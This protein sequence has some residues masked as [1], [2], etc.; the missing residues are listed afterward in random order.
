MFFKYDPLNE[1]Y[2]SV[3][4]GVAENTSV[5]FFVRTDAERAE[6]LLYGD[7]GLISLL[8][9]KCDDGFCT[10]TS[11]DRGLYFYKF[12][13]TDGKESVI[14]GA[15]EN[16]Y[17]LCD[18]AFFQLTVCP[19]DYVT[20]DSFKGGVIYQIFPDRFYRQ[21]DFTVPD[22]K[23]ARYDWGGTPTFR[24]HDGIVYNNEFF[25][26]NFRGIK[27]KLDYISSLGITAL[28]LNPISKSYSSHRYDTG[29]YLIPDPVL[30]SYEDFHDLALEARK[31]GIRLIYDGVF[32]HTGADSRY[33]NRYGNYSDGGA[34][35]DRFSP[36]YEWYTFR[37]YPDDYE[38]WWNFPN[39]PSVK[40][41]CESYQ[42][43]ICGKNG[44]LEYWLKAGFGGVRLDVADELT[45]DFIKKIRARVKSES[46]DNPL[47]GEVWED[48][49]NKIAY[50]V[51]RR[52]FTDGE[53]DSVM[54]Y[55]LR[56]AICDY[57][58]GGDCSFLVS[59]IRSQINNYPKAALDCLMNIISTHDS[60]RAITLFGRKDVIVDKDK[61]AGERLTADEYNRG[62]ARL[63]CAS[64]VQFFLY[65]VPSIYYGDE[66]GLS[67]NLDPYN[68]RCYDWDNPD[69][70]LLAHYRKISDIRKN[71]R[72]ALKDGK[73]EVLFA[74]KGVLI[75]SRGAADEK[76]IVAVNV[77]FKS[78]I[79][80]LSRRSVDLYS[81]KAGLK[82]DLIPQSF[83]ILKATA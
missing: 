35:R 72:A 3:T 50:G 79:V 30:G 56:D 42:S 76:L 15:D 14:Y 29:D 44:V 49:T 74:E 25:G 64:V 82:F 68:R 12:K 23:I 47:I 8:L 31:R 40:K 7:N 52:Y 10:R 62:K 20:P 59:V 61:M 37:N 67:G 4:G 71:N 54:N 16:N 6:M 9:E 32:N 51:R 45:D 70:E 21:G 69:K 63:I 27:E 78:H 58:L 53:L 11:L 34:Y 33:F 83:L 1:I 41:D 28:Y 57:V 48:A 24:A 5:R 19:S 38:C 66:E 2:K 73:T 65:G 26:G 75:F 81:G 17:A 55:P 22:G 80:S 18:G 39:L 36:Y 60:V 13:V 43:F 46:V 77:G